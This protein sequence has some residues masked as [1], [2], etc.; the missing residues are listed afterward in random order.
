MKLDKKDIAF[1]TVNQKSLER[2]FTNRLEELK[3]IVCDMPG[4]TEKDRAERD[5]VHT[6]IG[7]FRA[8]QK[9]L[10]NIGKKKEDKKED[11]I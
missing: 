9:A 1:V 8:W 10:L 7:E 3:N 4:T 5:R 6:L 11:Y 2:L